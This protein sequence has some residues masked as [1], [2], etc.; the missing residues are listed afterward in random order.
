MEMGLAL[1]SLREEA[2]MIPATKKLAAM[3]QTQRALS[4]AVRPSA[5]YLT[6]HHGKIRKL[7]FNTILFLKKLT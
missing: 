1:V 5:T 6:K 7:I 3:V 2:T 4:S